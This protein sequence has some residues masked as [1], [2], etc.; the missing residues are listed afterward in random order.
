MEASRETKEIST[1]GGH[2]AVVK[3]YL[4]AREVNNVLT[5]LFKSQDVSSDEAAN[6][7]AKISLI[8]GIQRN[9][10]LVEAAVVSLDGSA[11]NL[12]D[13]LQ[14]LPASEYTA[15]LNEV[16]GLADGNF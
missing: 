7:K 2:T 5:E 1:P 16:K 6:G 11:E 3:T 12:S 15:I 10:K 13:R 4:T 8:V 14:D 9:V